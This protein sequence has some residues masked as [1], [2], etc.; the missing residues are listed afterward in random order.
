[1]AGVLSSAVKELNDYL[2]IV[3]TESFDHL[4]IGA[5]K[6]ELEPILIVARS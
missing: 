3:T 5:D 2:K 4:Q 6:N 1:M